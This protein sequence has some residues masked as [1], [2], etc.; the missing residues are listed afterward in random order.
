[1]GAQGTSGDQPEGLQKAGSGRQPAGLGQNMEP[2]CREVIHNPRQGLEARPGG[3]HKRCCSRRHHRRWPTGG[4]R[5]LG[6][7]HLRARPGLAAAAWPPTWLQRPRSGSNTG[8]RR[9]SGEGEPERGEQNCH[10]LPLAPARRRGLQASSLA[11]GPLGLAQ[12]PAGRPGL[13]PSPQMLGLGAQVPQ[14]PV[15]SLQPG[16][17]GQTTGRG[18]SDPGLSSVRR[19]V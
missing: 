12:T 7:A 15:T 16:T 5:A 6:S 8:D 3:S 9:D 4:R 17:P 18:R 19:R 14:A 2:R 1:M 13:T 10:L 11:R